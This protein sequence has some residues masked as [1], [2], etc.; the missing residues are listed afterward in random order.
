MTTITTNCIASQQFTRMAKGCRSVLRAGRR[1]SGKLSA[2]F[3]M[4]PQQRADAYL[5]R[6]PIAVITD[7][8]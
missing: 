1:L 6:M 7:P 3:T 4:T 2:S 8:H 5:A